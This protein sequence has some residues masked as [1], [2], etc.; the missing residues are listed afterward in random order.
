MHGEIKFVECSLFITLRAACAEAISALAAIARPGGPTLFRAQVSGSWD[1]DAGFSRVTKVVEFGGDGDAV[2][3][4]V[5]SGNSHHKRPRDPA[6]VEAASAPQNPRLAAPKLANVRGGDLA[7]VGAAIGVEVHEPA[8]GCSRSDDDGDDDDD[9]GD[10]DDI[11]DV[12]LESA[13]EDE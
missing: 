11:P 5:D 3:A 1:G 6:D 8:G 9:S 4:A 7:T 12:V 13:D 10:D 2:D